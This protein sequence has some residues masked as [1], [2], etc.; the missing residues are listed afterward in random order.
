ME[1]GG[2]LPE[3][4]Q[5]QQGALSNVALLPGSLWRG[6]W[7]PLPM[8]I[9]VALISGRVQGLQGSQSWRAAEEHHQA[10]Q[11]KETPSSTLPLQDQSCFALLLHPPPTRGSNMGSNEEASKVKDHHIQRPIHP[12]A[13]LQ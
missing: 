4:D 10:N 13:P 6:W 1:G 7:R 9:V 3:E 12:L 2:N 5:P 11:S 8:Y